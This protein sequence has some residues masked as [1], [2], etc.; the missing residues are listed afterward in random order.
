MGTRTPDLYRVKELGYRGNSYCLRC[1]PH[2]HYPEDD[3]IL[4]S[5]GDELVMRSCNWENED[6]PT[7]ALDEQAKK[8]R[9]LVLMGFIDSLLGKNL[10]LQRG[11]TQIENRP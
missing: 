9:T 1:F 3:P 5:F 4:P 11:N 8:K 6:S 7:V 10:I 2:F